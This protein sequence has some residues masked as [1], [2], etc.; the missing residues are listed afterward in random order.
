MDSGAQVESLISP[1]IFFSIFVQIGFYLQ[2]G[3]PIIRNFSAYHNISRIFQGIG[4]F[5]APGYF[6]H[7]GVPF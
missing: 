6:S 5:W 7:P 1:D 3:I 2:Q 4:D